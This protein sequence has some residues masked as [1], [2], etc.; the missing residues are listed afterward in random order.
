MQSKS[1]SFQ[2]VSGVIIG[3]IMGHSICTG[4]AVLGGRMIAQRISVKTG[5]LL[6]LSK[7]LRLCGLITFFFSSNNCGRCGLPALRVFGTIFRSER[8]LGISRRIYFAQRP[9]CKLGTI[10]IGLDFLPGVL[11]F[12]FF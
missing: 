1:M 7:F 5:K 2:D 11:T 8:G 6:K 4:I 3:G 10:Y 9:Y 12:F